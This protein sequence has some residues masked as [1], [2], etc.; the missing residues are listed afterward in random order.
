MIEANLGFSYNGALEQ[1]ILIP[2]SGSTP[3]KHGKARHPICHDVVNMDEAET[4]VRI[5][6]VSVDH[7]PL[8]VASAIVCD[9][10]IAEDWA[11][12]VLYHLWGKALYDAPVGFLH[13]IRIFNN[14]SIFPTNHLVPAI[15]GASDGERHSHYD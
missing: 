5:C 7:L 8:R 15:S 10:A 13:Q 1:E 11:P 6:R 4:R 12:V 3:C 2:S 9:G 14:T